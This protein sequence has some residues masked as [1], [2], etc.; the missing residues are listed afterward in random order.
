MLVGLTSV[1]S[2]SIIIVC[3]MLTYPQ[4]RGAQLVGT[5][6]VQAVPLVTSAAIAHMLVGD[7]EL[8]LT[9]SILIGAL[10][11]V[12]VG[13]RLSSKAPDGIIRP[14][15]VFVLL[16]SALK[17]L[18]VPTGVLGVIL[19]A[20]ILMGIPIWGAVDAAAHPQYLWDAGGAPPA[21]VDQVDGVRGAVR[22]GVPGRGGVLRER[23]AEAGRRHACVAGRSEPRAGAR[24]RA[25][26]RAGVAVF[27]RILLAVDGSPKSEKTILIALDM[28]E[29]YAS[30]VTVVHVREYERYEGSDVDMGPPIPAEELVNDVLARF[31]DKG[32]EARGEIRRVSSGDTPEKIVEVAEAVT[33]DLIVLG[34][35]GMSEWKSLVLGGVANKV[36][37][38]ATCPVL[39]VR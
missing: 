26:R 10:P 37:Q 15:L 5:D 32:I 31:R 33:A 20:V 2:G 8:G 34:S 9:T 11:A 29:R 18:D 4:L 12:Y 23:T 38:H 16:A 22:R 24:T 1:G 6:L 35:R 13:A 39:L 25:N 3:L 28:A 14:I 21:H 30:A 19:L 27:E 36:V 17:L 7:F